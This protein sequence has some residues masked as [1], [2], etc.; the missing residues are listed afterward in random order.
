[1]EEK[2]TIATFD[3]YY[4]AHIF[5]TKLESEGIDCFLLDENVN[6]IIP[7]ASSSFG[8]IKAQVFLSDSLRAADIYFDG[9]EEH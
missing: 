8:G 5:K 6:S 7:M 1:M 2:V 4:R 9:L 3:N